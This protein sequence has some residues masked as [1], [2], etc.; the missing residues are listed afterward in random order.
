VPRSTTS[1]GIVA[2]V[3]MLVACSP[4]PERVCE[5]VIELT[6]A[7]LGVEAIP[8]DKRGAWLEGCVRDATRDREADSKTYG[9]QSKCVLAAA[10]LEALRECD[11]PPSADK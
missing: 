8:A 5:H 1:L 3:A 7:E 11:K 10:S 9:R 4:S 2:L 6:E